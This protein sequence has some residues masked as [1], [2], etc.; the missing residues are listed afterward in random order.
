MTPVSEG[1]RGFVRRDDASHVRDHAGRAA[2]LD[3]LPSDDRLNADL[4][5]VGL[6]Q[7]R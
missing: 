6:A 4:D 5:H 1:F 3:R 2:L 7:C